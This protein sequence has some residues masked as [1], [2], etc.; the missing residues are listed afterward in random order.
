VI[1]YVDTSVL[2][3]VIIEETG[4]SAAAELWDA[5]EV[6]AV[7]RIGHV[8]A[9]AALAAARRGE[10]LTAPQLGSAKATLDGLWSQLTVVEVTE[11]LVD[12]AAELA[13]VERLRGYDA[14][15][16]AAAMEISADVVTSADN[17]L[18]RAAAR[19]GLHTADPTAG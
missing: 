17:D 10:R 14:V 19:V 16:L 2:I 13:E 1:T 6:L 3:K 9:R 8:E 12:D 4:S 7:V 18:L 5:S 15:H 11:G